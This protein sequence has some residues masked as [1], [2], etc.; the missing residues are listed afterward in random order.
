MRLLAAGESQGKGL[1]G[2]LEGLPSGVR[3]DTER[4]N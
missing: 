3:I 2:I 1:V 4:V